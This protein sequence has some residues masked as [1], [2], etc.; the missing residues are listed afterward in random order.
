[1]F[2]AL[3]FL[4]EH[5]TSRWLHLRE[6]REELDVETRLEGIPT[7][8]LFRHGVV[9]GGHVEQLHPWELSGGL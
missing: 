4:V 1:M 6:A 2:E 7:V 8:V 9:T 5:S 3:H